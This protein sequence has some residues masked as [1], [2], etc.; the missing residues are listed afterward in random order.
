[1]HRDGSWQ[2]Q[3]HFGSNPKS[4]LHQFPRTWHLCLTLMTR[5]SANNTAWKIWHHNSNDEPVKIQSCSLSL[6]V[7]HQMISGHWAKLCEGL[8][9]T[10]KNAARSWWSSSETHKW[11]DTKED[12]C[13]NMP[14][15]KVDA[16]SFADDVNWPLLAPQS[17]QLT[18]CVLCMLNKTNPREQLSF[19]NAIIW[20]WSDT[21]HAQRAD[22]Q[23][24]L[25]HLLPESSDWEGLCSMVF[26]CNESPMNIKLIPWSRL[27]ERHSVVLSQRAKICGQDHLNAS[28]N[29]SYTFHRIV[30]LECPNSGNDAICF[31]R[32]TFS[33]FCNEMNS[34]C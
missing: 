11:F 24:T 13:G 3:T 33:M 1:M 8:A 32:S 5:L 7:A 20:V 16:P 18:G 19:W 30:L 4:A 28:C 12:A 6:K 15:S 25:N 9:N 2:L 14:W 26:G 29:I 31:A 23:F 27:T 21:W 17:E 10:D 34:K 22:H